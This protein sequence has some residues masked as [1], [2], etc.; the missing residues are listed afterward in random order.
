MNISEFDYNLPPDL[1]AHEPVHPRDASRMMVVDSKREVISHRKFSNLPEVLHPNDVLVINDTRVIR[2]RTI[3]RLERTSGTSRSIEVFFAESM[4]ESGISWQVLCK[5]ARRIRAGDRAI[6]GNGEIS[7]VFKEGLGADLHILELESSDSIR[8][9]LAQ[10][11]Q[12]PLPPY[13]NR[14]ETETG[15]D[16]YQTVYA[17][18]SG[19]VAAPTAGLHFTPEVLSAIRTRGVEV[20]NITLHVGIG[21]FLP[22]RTEAVEDHVL[23][24]ERFEI[25]EAAA[26][27]L[28]SAH[29]G[30]RKIIAV[31]TTTT[32]TLEFLVREYGEIRAGTGKTDLY[33]LPGFQF[34]IVGALLTNFHLPRSTLFMLVSAFA[35]RDAIREAYRQAIQ[36]RY[37]FYSYGDCMFIQ[38]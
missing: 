3:A 25:T 15:E 31:G 4:D 33:I 29:R 1:I 35:G 18:H 34:Q 30:G 5:P 36:E 6:F 37:R 20:V 8:Q 11:G 24:P 14:S 23:R 38:R 26:K 12:I 16:D 28:K 10:F 13:I 7:G 17:V 19:A 21:T 2:A 9:I 27:S 32:R 22:V